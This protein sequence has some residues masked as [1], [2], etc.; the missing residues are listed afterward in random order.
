MNRKSIISL[1]TLDDVFDINQHAILLHEDTGVARAMKI[2]A[3][4]ERTVKNMTFFNQPL[5]YDLTQDENYNGA[6]FTKSLSSL[7]PSYAKVAIGHFWFDGGGTSHI[8]TTIYTDSSLQNSWYLH[9]SQNNDKWGRWDHGNK[10]SVPLNTV[11]P[12]D[13]GN[14]HFRIVAQDTEHAIDNAVSL[15]IHGYI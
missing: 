11:F 7:V 9:V 4:Q 5:I 6:D 14:I 1:P 15:T 13:Q 3:L 12:L 8:T 10:H 2:S